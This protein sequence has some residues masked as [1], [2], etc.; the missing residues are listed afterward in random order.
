MKKVENLP[1]DFINGADVSSV[2]SLEA[3]GVVFRDA[4]GQVADLFD[5]LADHGVTDV[6]VRVWNDPFDADGNGYGGGDVDVARAVEIGERATDAG[7]GV[8]VDF[9]YSDAAERRTGFGQCR[10]IR[11]GCRFPARIRQRHPNPVPPVPP[12]AALTRGGRAGAWQTGRAPARPR[13]V[14]SAVV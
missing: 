9:H 5:V 3:S 4:D 11:T 12:L 10:R 1:A 2:L 14:R 13:T 7:L 8:L 6:R